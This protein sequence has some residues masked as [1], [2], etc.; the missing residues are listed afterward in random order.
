MK[1]VKP[2]SHLCTRYL[3]VLIIDHHENLY[4]MQYAVPYLQSYSSQFLETAECWHIVPAVY[5]TVY[6]VIQIFATTSVPK[7]KSWLCHK[8]NFFN[9]DQVNRKIYQHLELQISF[10]KSVIV[11]IFILYSFDIIDLI[12]FFYKHGQLE[13]VWLRTSY[14]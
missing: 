8:S 4:I 13:E 3:C 2:F 12:R 9:F 14:I 5:H 7:Y 1:K 10:I 6:Q 11:Y